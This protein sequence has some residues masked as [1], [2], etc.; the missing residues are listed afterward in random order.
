MRET[1]EIGAMNSGTATEAGGREQCRNL[2]IEIPPVWWS[3]KETKKEN[4][5]L[6]ARSLSY[7]SRDPNS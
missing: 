7:T 6:L 5:H 4:Q 3:E 1:R 2:V